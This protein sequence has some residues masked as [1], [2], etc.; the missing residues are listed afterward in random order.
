M[1]YTFNTKEMS[2]YTND[3]GEKVSTLRYYFIRTKEEY[4]FGFS[5][6]TGK[7]VP[8]IQC[9]LTKQ[10]FPTKKYSWFFYISIP[11]KHQKRWLRWCAGSESANSKKRRKS[12]APE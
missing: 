2:N 5:E 11:V 10:I 1:N 8:V 4:E 3:A 7:R 9:W 6:A 12:N